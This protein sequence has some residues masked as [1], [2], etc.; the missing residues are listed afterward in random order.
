MPKTYARKPEHYFKLQAQF[1]GL[2][3]LIFDILSRK[4]PPHP[5]P[6]SKPQRSAALRTLYLYSAP[7][8]FHEGRLWEICDVKRCLWLHG[9]GSVSPRSQDRPPNLLEA[10]EKCIKQEVFCEAFQRNP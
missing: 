3:L 8:S 4:L 2:G 1:S 10:A 7:P 5:Q 9:K 6:A